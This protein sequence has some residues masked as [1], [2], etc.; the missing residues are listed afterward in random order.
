MRNPGLQLL[1]DLVQPSVWT[2]WCATG[3]RVTEW[4]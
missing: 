2:V 4:R 3:R 1:E